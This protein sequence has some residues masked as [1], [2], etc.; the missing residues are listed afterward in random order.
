MQLVAG[1][2]GGEGTGEL[3]P[4]TASQVWAVFGRAL[5]ALPSQKQRASLMQCIGKWADGGCSGG[6]AAE[7]PAQVWLSSFHAL[8]PSRPAAAVARSLAT[9]RRAHR[10]AGLGGAARGSPFLQRC[11][12][13]VNVTGLAQKLG[14]LEAVNREVQSKYWSNLQLLGQ[15]W[16]FDAFYFHLVVP[17]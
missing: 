6:G 13:S 14:Q 2:Y 11:S 4:H 10:A 5:R 17:R 9:L 3:P 7:P 8:A 16:N 12:L 15:P 1:A